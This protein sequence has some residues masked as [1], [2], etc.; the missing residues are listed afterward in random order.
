MKMAQTKL[1]SLPYNHYI[2]GFEKMFNDLRFKVVYDIKDLSQNRK[3][4]SESFES[5]NI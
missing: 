5:R 2:E 4:E 1:M 3:N